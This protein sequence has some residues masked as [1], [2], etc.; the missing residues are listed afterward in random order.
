MAQ[1]AVRLLSL[2]GFRKGFSNRGRPAREME[3]VHVRATIP[4]EEKMKQASNE[5]W[6]RLIV[7]MLVA[8]ERNRMLKQLHHLRVEI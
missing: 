7:E 1:Y 4:R 3:R 8:I 2:C 6:N 5:T